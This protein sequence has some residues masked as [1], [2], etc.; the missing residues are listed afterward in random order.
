MMDLI[1]EVPSC[2]WERVK[3]VIINMDLAIG[4]RQFA[5]KIEPP[6]DDDHRSVAGVLTHLRRF[7]RV[8]ANFCGASN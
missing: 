2:T 8:A 6:S 1:C 5:L 7:D 3:I 4:D